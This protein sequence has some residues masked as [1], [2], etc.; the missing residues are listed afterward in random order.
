MFEWDFG[1]RKCGSAFA[2]SGGGGV[3]GK[4]DGDGRRV[5]S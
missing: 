3:V 5:D 1:L 2:M 4:A